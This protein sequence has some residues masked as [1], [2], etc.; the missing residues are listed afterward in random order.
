MMV[1]AIDAAIEK[2]AH[3]MWQGSCDK[4]DNITFSAA[5]RFQVLIQ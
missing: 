2:L 4:I 1:K 3:Q 5:S